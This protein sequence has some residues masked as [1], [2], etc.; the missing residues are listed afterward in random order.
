[1][2]SL[3]ITIRSIPVRLKIY[4]IYILQTLLLSN[5]T[6]TNLSSTCQILSSSTRHSL[7]NLYIS[8]TILFCRRSKNI[9]YTTIS[10]PIID[11]LPI[12][13]I[14]LIVNTSCCQ[15]ATIVISMLS[16]S[17]SLMHPHQGSRSLAIKSIIPIHQVDN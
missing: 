6:S 4:Y 11:L 1:M 2:N 10:A 5:Q 13:L 12:S 7:T 16:T 15:L 9:I 14:R 8:I 17:R 3:S